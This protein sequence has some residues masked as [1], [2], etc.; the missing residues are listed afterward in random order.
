[1]SLTDGHIV[2]AGTYATFRQD[3]AGRRRPWSHYLAQPGVLEVLGQGVQRKPLDRFPAR[4]VGNATRLDLGAVNVRALAVDSAQRILD[5]NPP[6]REPA[7]SVALV[8]RDVGPAG[9]R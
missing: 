8:G 7:Y 2:Q 3:P 4:A 5:H 6:F 1:M 9:R